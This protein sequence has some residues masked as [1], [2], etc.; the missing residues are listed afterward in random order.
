M[1]VSYNKLFKLLIDKNMKKQDLARL[2]KISPATITKMVTGENITM[3]IIEKVC[4]SLDCKVDD[5]L[6]FLD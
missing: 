4:R 5:I 6:D 2:A 1:A 3:E